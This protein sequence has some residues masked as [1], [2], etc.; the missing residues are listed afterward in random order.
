MTMEI[1]FSPKQQEI[2]TRPF[3]H[4]LEANEGTPRSGKTTAGHFRYALYLSLTPDQNHLIV[5]YNQEQAYRLFID[6]D[7]TG[8]KHQFGNLA[9]V[10]HDDLG[11]HLEVQTPTGVKKVY[12]KGGGKVDS[13]KAITGM[14]LGSVV[15]CEINL[16]HM[17]M[18]QECFRRT[19]AAK[20]RYHLADLNPPA[21]NHPVIK[22]VFE[23]QD[24]RW[25]HWTIDDNPILTAERKQ[26]IYNTLVKNPYLLKRD[27]EGKRVNPQGVIYGMLDLE[28][29]TTK[30]L[31][32]KPLEMFFTADGGQSDATSVSCNIITRYQGKPRLNRVAHYYHSGADTGQVKAMSEYAREIKEFVRYCVDKYEMRYRD[33]FVDPA[34]KSLREELRLV[35]IATMTADNNARDIKGSSKGIEVGIERAQNTIT[36]DQLFL[37]D[38]DKF[39]HYHFIKEAGLYCRDDNGK[40]IDKDNHSMDEFRYSVNYFYKKYV[41]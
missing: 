19:F 25:T 24:T 38:D 20:M 7:G 41:K 37:V 22:D 9:K 33:F 4:T 16:L 39:D 5:A 26:E 11:D 8:L 14:S 34:C 31:L 18:I 23:V 1:K 35:R 28:K 40:P 29:H 21:P 15:F 30:T 32:G 36:N 12:Y 3:D 13:V 2:I 10:K 17:D 27:W 6:G